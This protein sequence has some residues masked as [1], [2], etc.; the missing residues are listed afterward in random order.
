MASENRQPLADITNVINSPLETR[1]RSRTLELRRKCAKLN[2]ENIGL[3]HSITLCHQ[4][5]QE[6][7]EM[8]ERYRYQIQTFTDSYAEIEKLLKANNRDIIVYRDSYDFFF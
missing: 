1:V 6:L 2:A 8:L 7:E 4:D 5:I 3:R